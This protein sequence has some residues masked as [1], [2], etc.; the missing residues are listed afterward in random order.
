LL[1]LFLPHYQEYHLKPSQFDTYEHFYKNGAVKCGGNFQRVHS[2]DNKA[3][4]EIESD[5]IDQAKQL[6]E[7]NIDLED[8]WAQLCPETERERLR[9]LDLMKDRVVD[10]EDADGTELMPDLTANPHTACTL[11][12]NHVT[13]PRQDAL[14]LLRSLNGQQSAVFYAV[15]QWCLQKLLGQNPEPLRLFITGGAGTGKSHLIK[16]IHYEATR[17]LS[18]IAENPE[19][20]TVLL[21]APTGVAAYDIGAA[22]IHHF[23]HWCKCQDALSTSRR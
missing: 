18:Q 7:D 1:Q 4:F 3:V 13:M 6:L 15:R 21:T 16:A 14:D 19:D 5:A 8:A 2:I 10:D 12:T 22:T 17:L 23:L 20:L 9:C 11:E